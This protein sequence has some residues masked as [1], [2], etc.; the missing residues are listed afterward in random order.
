[1]LGFTLPQNKMPKPYHIPEDAPKSVLIDLHREILITNPR[2]RCHFRWGD[3]TEYSVKLNQRDVEHIAARKIA[4]TAPFRLVV[5]T[6]FEAADIDG[7]TPIVTALE[8]WDGT[9]GE[10]YPAF[11][12]LDTAGEILDTDES[13]FLQRVNEFIFQRYPALDALIRIDILMFTVH[14]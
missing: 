6:D 2:I 13:G 3:F 7:D 4:T 10:W 14:K 8:V 5:G 1:M 12:M 9:R 11:E